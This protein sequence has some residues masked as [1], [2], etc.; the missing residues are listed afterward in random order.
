MTPY[1]QVTESHLQPE[2]YGISEYLGYLFYP[3]FFLAGPIV[4]F[5]AFVSQVSS[6]II[7]LKKTFNYYRWKNHKLLIVA[8]K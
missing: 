7:F 8:K 6:L 1:I 5:N 4:S 3:C 2:K